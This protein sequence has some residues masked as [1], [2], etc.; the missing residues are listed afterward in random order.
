[1]PSPVHVSHAAGHSQIITWLG[2]YC[3][4][5]PGVKL[6]DNA[7]TRLDLDNVVQPDMLLRLEPEH[8]GRSRITP[9]DYVEGTPE[10]D[11]RDRHRRRG[12]RSARQAAGLPAQP[13]AGVRSLADPG[14]AVGLVALGRGR[15]R[16]A[17]AG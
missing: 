5:T 12:L 9:D 13:G 2:V 7:T 11:R 4:A 15:L 10:Y 14:G 6:A 8:G 1:M 17:G 3:T 16:A